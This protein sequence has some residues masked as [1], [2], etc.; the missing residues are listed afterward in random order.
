MTKKWIMLLG[1]ASMLVLSACGQAASQSA[2]APK[3]NV[4]AS[5]TPATTAPAT[6]KPTEDTVTKD[7]RIA[8]ISIFL[9]SDLLALGISPVGSATSDYLPTVPERFK[10]TK[11][12]GFTKDPDME[13]LL[14]LKPDA[15]Y[16]DAEFAGKQGLAKYEKIAKTHVIN[17]DEG[18]WRDHLKAI[19]KLVN[20][21]QK[22]EDFIK[23][24][25]AQTER[26]KALI[27]NKIGDGTVMAV[28][29][30]AKNLRVYGMGRPLGPILFND[31]GLKPAKGVE[32]IT[33][34]FEVISQEVF[35]DYDAD[36][37]FVLVGFE[38][39]NDKVYEQLKNNPIWQ[40]LK[41][42][43]ANKVYMITEQPWLDY[44]ALGNKLALDSLEKL[45]AK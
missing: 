36:A 11:F 37:I 39:G 1:M 21:E 15:I 16:I 4:A 43:K 45:F 42:V 26:V 10:N 25:E 29:I 32:K 41:A 17:L 9:T 12:L 31:L 44:S 23:D 24:Y 35:P 30:S 3:S 33:K 18:T 13:A 19:G 27:H 40:G 7:P 34:N 8:S 2:M 5:T 14:A 22:A 38:E 20:R 6:G 28:R